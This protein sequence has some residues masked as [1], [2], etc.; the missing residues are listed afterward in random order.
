MNSFAGNAPL[1]R[2][3][4]HSIGQNR[5]AHAYIFNGP[6]GVGKKRTALDLA[7]AV[8][9]AARPAGLDSCGECP[10]CRKIAAGAHPDVHL[11]APA[12]KVFLIE[13]I[14]EIIREIQ[15]QPFEGQRRLFILDNSDRMNDESANCLLKTLEE[16]PDKNILVLITANLS[17]LLP[18]IRSRSQILNFLPVP[19]SIV[20]NFLIERAGAH[21]AHAARAA[22][23]GMGS[24]GTALT[25]DPDTLE[26][27]REDAFHLLEVL[28]I[29]DDAALLELFQ[30]TFGPEFQKVESGKLDFDLFSQIFIS[31]LRD[32]IIMEGFQDRDH[33][34]FYDH[35][36]RLVRLKQM[37]TPA[38]IGMVLHDLEEMQR[39][40]P[41]YLKNDLLF[42]NL[43]L[44]CRAAMT[45][46]NRNVST[47]RH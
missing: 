27:M 5:L 9:C 15:Y 42:L 12:K 28:T 17:A 16:P 1:R 6:E 8:N 24:I 36:E 35:L 14:R 21:P 37:Y 23:L 41:F 26:S 18:T 45:M 4:H 44:K 33:L 13:Q 19:T 31:I 2:L 22:R 7:A 47:G 32:L 40:R 25:L 38:I 43:L 34:L 39:K 20:E 3:L 29:Q 46:R 11:V 30:T 10:S